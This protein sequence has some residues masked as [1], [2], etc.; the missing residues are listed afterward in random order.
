M[1]EYSQFLGC[2]VTVRYRVGEMLLSASG[3]F[4]ADSGRSIFLEQHLD[5]HGTRKYFR[6]EIP[7]PYIYRIAAELPAEG[8]EKSE[9][10]GADTEES[11]DESL[12]KSA[13]AG[14]GDASSGGS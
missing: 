7:Y 10:C 14:A 9:M 4:S 11:H 12:R 6:W 5:Q 13:A 3:T 8:A 2:R 1:A